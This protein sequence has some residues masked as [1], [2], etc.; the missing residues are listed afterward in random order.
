M[1][2]KPLLALILAACGLSST[3]TS[4][5]AEPPAEQPDDLDPTEPGHQEDQHF[6][7]QSVDPKTKTGEGCETIGSGKIDLCAEVLYCSGDW[8]K[9]DGKVY[10]L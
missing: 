2:S 6:C 7:C 4:A 9:H 5:T 10:C 3:P 8:A 1:I